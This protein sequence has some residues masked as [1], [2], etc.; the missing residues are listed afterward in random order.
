VTSV[1]HAAGP[2]LAPV[3]MRLTLCASLIPVLALAE[4]VAALGAAGAAVAIDV[5]L[6]LGLANGAL[7]A[8]SRATARLLCVLALVPLIRPIGMATSLDPIPR[9]LWPVVAGAPLLVAS[10]WAA[11][12]VGYPVVDRLLRSSAPGLLLALLCGSFLGLGAYVTAGFPEP[13]LA[14][15]WLLLAGAGLMLV[16]APAQE[17]LFRGVLQRLVADTFGGRTALLVVLNGLFGATLLGVSFAF[18]L[19]MGAVGMAF[20][21]FVRSR[22]SLG[23]VVVAHAGLSAYGLLV[24]PF[25]LG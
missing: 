16:A 4:A 15:P 25:V 8:R 2:R 1:A 24:W 11:R 7:F 12:T 14:A 22:G 17:I 5:G 3:R 6:V 19:Y 23:E 13:D 10:L 20:S 18:G 21:S 9:E